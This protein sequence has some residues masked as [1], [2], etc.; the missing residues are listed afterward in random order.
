[1]KIKKL[2]RLED[3]KLLNVSINTEEFKKNLKSTEL[4]GLSKI[5]TVF[6]HNQASLLKIL[7]LRGPIK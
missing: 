6:L 7:D 5:E 4:G 2:I 3:L 1:M